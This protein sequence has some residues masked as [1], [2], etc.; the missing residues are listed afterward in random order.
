MGA[1]TLALLVPLVMVQGT[2]SERAGRREEAVREV[3]GTWGAPQ[4]FGGPVLSIPY[5]IAW[6]DGSGRPQRAQHRVQVLARELRI[7]GAVVPEQRRRGIFEVMVYR[8]ELKVSGRFVRPDLAWLKPSPSEIDWNQATLSIGVSDPKGLTKRGALDWNGRTVPFSGGIADVVLFGSG[9]HAVITGLDTVTPG[10]DVPFAFTIDMNGTRDLFFLPSAEETTVT[11]SSSWPHPS[12]SGAPLPQSRTTGDAGFTGRWA[13]T[14]F[15]R[16]Y[17]A[18]WSN[19]G[20]DR[21]QLIAMAQASA[22]GVSL[23]QPVDIYQ[24]AERAVKYAILFIVLTFLVFFLW[25]V[26]QATL[27]HPMQYA[28]V[29]F[30]LCLFYLL[31]LSISEHTGFDTAYAIS[32]V[33]A[34]TLIGGYSRAVLRGTR[35]ALSVVGALAA[36]YGFLYLL[37]RLEDYALLAGS[38]GMFV[39]LAFVMFITRRMNWYE[40]RLGQSD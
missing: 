12:F 10:T 4:T 19:A 21:Q 26:F 7:D 17:P 37:L 39:V 24:Q 9:I 38:V 33:A 3:S 27:L 1:L 18:R 36:L 2:V 5:T 32:S 31:L 8:T 20:T 16:A 40:L 28:F 22:F 14:D 29:G 25:E 30:A 34:T 13:V 6:T 11:L 15:G 35:P 23:L